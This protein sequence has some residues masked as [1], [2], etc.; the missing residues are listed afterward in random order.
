M[1][2]PTAVELGLTGG[3]ISPGAATEGAGSLA[4]CS[5]SSA[6]SF[7]YGGKGLAAFV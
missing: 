1:D 2:Q 3:L 7:W 6:L 5:S 4:D